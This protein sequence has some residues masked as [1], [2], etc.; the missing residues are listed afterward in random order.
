MIGIVIGNDGVWEVGEGERRL[1]YGTEGVEKR[2]MK[3]SIQMEQIARG[4]GV[5]VCVLIGRE[6]RRRK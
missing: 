3:D 1:E 4:K 5:G 6:E 2:D